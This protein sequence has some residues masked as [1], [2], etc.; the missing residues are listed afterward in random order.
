[1]SFVVFRLG[2]GIFW[3]GLQIRICGFH[4]MEEDILIFR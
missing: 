1:M 4:G 3:L 2:F